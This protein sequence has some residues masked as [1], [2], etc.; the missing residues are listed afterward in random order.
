MRRCALASCSRSLHGGE[1]G[2]AGR[3][4]PRG[5]ED[6]RR[7]AARDRPARHQRQSHCVRHRLPPFTSGA[8]S[9]RRGA[10]RARSSNSSARSPCR[11][12]RARSTR[13]PPIA[14][15]PSPRGGR[16]ER[17][18]DAALL[19][20]YD[21]LLTDALV[22]LGHS[23]DVRQGR[24]RRVDPNWNMAREIRGFEPAAEVQR[25]LDAGD[26]YQALEREKP[27]HH[28]YAG[29]KRELARYRQIEAAGGWPSSSRGASLSSRGRDGRVP[30]LRS[31][32]HEATGG[33][34]RQGT[35]PRRA[36]IRHSPPRAQLSGAHGPRR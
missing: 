3:C 16:G 26:V 13:L 22:R 32:R 18:A 9:A 5:A 25:T 8:D 2:G 15:R 17:Q 10:T 34:V 19:A 7:R 24:P 14:P 31:R 29:L 12:R 1:C 6:A 4:D 28:V 33:L 21:L 20:D 30:A 36:T 27:G 11:G 35:T 23:P